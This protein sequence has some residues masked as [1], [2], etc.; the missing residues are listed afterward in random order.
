VTFNH[1]VE[2]SSPSALT[3]KIRHN[4]HF[5]F[6]ATAD[7]EVVGKRGGMLMPIDDTATWSQGALAFKSIFDGLRSA[8]SMVREAKGSRDADQGKEETKLIE[9]ALEKASAATAIAEAEVAKALGFELCKCQFPPI[10]MLT[11]GHIDNPNAKMVGP[12]YE[13]PKCGYN[14]ARVWSYTRTAPPRAKEA[15]ASS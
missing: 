10:P 12:V 4:L 9:A 2:G 13:C 15:A 3:N 14:S 8:I 11:V 6:P 7:W 1:G 5:C